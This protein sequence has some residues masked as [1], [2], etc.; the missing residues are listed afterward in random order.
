MFA[1]GFPWWGKWEERQP[2]W[3]VRAATEHFSSKDQ[4]LT[5]ALAAPGPEFTDFEVTR[6][7]WKLARETGA[8]ITT[9]VGVGSYGQDAKVQEMGEAGLLGPDTT[10]IHCTTLNDTEIQMIVDTGGTVS[11]ASPV[12]MMMGHGM[13]P[14]QKFLDR[15]LRPSLSVDVETNVPSDMFNQMRSVLALQ[16]A[17]GHRAR[18]RRRLGPKEVLLCATIEGARANGLDAKVGTL[19]PGKQADLI[20]LRT[21]RIN[22]TPLNDPA[23]AVVSG[24]DTGNVDTV[25]IA[26]PGHET[27]RRAAPRRLAGGEADGRRVQGLRHRQVGLQ[28]PEHLRGGRHETS[29]TGHGRRCHWTR[30]PWASY[31]DVWRLSV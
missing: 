5:L 11:L 9:H 23:T 29:E 17:I 16:R 28:A 6:D 25:V 2:S 10:Y 24:M 7:H 30:R 3:F 18:A 8:R 14:I 1:Y 22:V 31:A 13:P 26:G 19:T 4:M 20:M 21:D 15:G 12:E 27:S